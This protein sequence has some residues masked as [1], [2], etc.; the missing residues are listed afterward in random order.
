MARWEDGGVNTYRRGLR[1]CRCRS[2]QRDG[3]FRRDAVRRQRPGGQAGRA[4]LGNETGSPVGLLVATGC[5]SSGEEGLG[6]L[7]KG[8]RNWISGAA[9]RE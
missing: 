2:K 3:H 6:L 9:G 4:W 5:Q 7:S 1:R 8:R